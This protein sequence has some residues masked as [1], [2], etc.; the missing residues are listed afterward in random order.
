MKNI[1]KSSNS[2]LLHNKVSDITITDIIRNRRS[3]YADEFTGEN[4]S[5]EII[6]EILTNATWA[7]THKLT[8]PWRFIVFKGE[9]LKEYGLYLSEYYK[10]YYKNKLLPDDFLLKHNFLKEYPL[11][12]ACMIGIVFVKNSKSKLPEWEELAAVS[13]AVQNM[14]LTCTSYN[15]GSY[16]STPDGAI[17]FVSKFGL[18]EN[19]QSLGLFYI[20]CY[21]HLNYKSKKKRS[22]LANKVS[23][24]THKK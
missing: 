11:K 21:D 18:K 7:P 8:E 16:W 13:S 3:V 5:D 9:Y 19:E 15:L 4:I 10:E 17:D 12:A 20:G 2:R 14:A 22:P 1:H 24:L 6:E 23:W